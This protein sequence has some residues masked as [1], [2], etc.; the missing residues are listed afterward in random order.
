MADTVALRT[1]DDAAWSIF[2]ATHDDVDAAGSRHCLR[3]RHLQ[4]RGEA[5]E[6]KVEELASFGLAHLARLAEDEC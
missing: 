4:E 6:G 2:C 1:A 3:E 5:C